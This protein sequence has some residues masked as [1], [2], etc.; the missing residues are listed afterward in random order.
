MVACEHGVFDR[1]NQRMKD[2][3]YLLVDRLE[4]RN[5]L[6]NTERMKPSW[7][8][9]HELP[10]RWY[11]WLW[12]FFPRD[13]RYTVHHSVPVELNHLGK[14]RRI[15]LTGGELSE[16]QKT[17]LA[18]NEL[19]EEEKT[20]LNE[21]TLTDEQKALLAQEGPK[22]LTQSAQTKYERVIVICPNNFGSMPGR[23]ICFTL[24]AGPLENY[25]ILEEALTDNFEHIKSLR[26][27]PTPVRLLAGAWQSGVLT[28]YEGFHNREEI[29]RV[30][31]ATFDTF[32][33]DNEIV[34]S[35]RQIHPLVVEFF[36]D[37]R[38]ANQPTWVQYWFDS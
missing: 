20:Y 5:I 11:D 35:R 6:P 3:S 25:S 24:L 14:A 8:V 23:N 1:E 7:Q 31:I 17:L 15:L 30:S 13:K 33:I 36:Q 37:I 22:P 2:V 32:P 16:D 4:I 10:P 21:H 9:S 34:Q 38:L 26:L 12:H 28:L 18:E 29:R 19:T 27:V